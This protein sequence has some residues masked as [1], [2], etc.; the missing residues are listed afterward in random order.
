MKSQ[1]KIEPPACPDADP[2]FNSASLGY[3]AFGIGVNSKLEMGLYTKPRYLLDCAPVLACGVSP[4]NGDQPPQF[5][6]WDTTRLP[7]KSNL[8]AGFRRSR[9]RASPPPWLPVVMAVATSSKTK[10]P[11]QRV[12]RFS[13]FSLMSLGGRGG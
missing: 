8:G 1:E 11:N 9:A 4:R 3:P 2:G 10:P 7:A 12:S 13:E 6:V 5:I